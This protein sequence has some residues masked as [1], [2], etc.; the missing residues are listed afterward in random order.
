MRLAGRISWASSAAAAGSR[1]RPGAGEARRLGLCCA[2][3]AATKFIIGTQAPPP[4]DQRAPAPWS[5]RRTGHF[6]TLSGVL[7]RLKRVGRPQRGG[8]AP[9]RRSASALPPNAT[10]SS[11]FGR[12]PR[13]SF[14]STL[15]LTSPTDAGRAEPIHFRAAR[16]CVSK[17]GG[18]GSVR[19]R[20]RPAAG[21]ERERVGCSQLRE[22]GVSR[23]LDVLFF[24]LFSAPVR[25][26]SNHR[27]V[28]MHRGFAVRWWGRGRSRHYG[29]RLR[30]Y[31]GS[32]GPA[33]GGTGRG[34]RHTFREAS[35]QR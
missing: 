9:R 34:H 1:T 25:W 5:T 13:F 19:V 16:A 30:Q 20:D 3:C 31:W 27:P 15:P 11:A 6:G 35:A 32:G 23:P 21:S 8:A 17:T 28:H 4:A 18:A 24:L 12:R 7:V 29:G 26:A 14:V 2:A 22:G 10:L 33:L